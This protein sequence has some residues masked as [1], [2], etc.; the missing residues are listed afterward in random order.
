MAVQ[1]DIKDYVDQKLIEQSNLKRCPLFADWV[2]QTMELLRDI[3][4]R[5]ER[6]GVAR[7]EQIGAPRAKARLH[8][9]KILNPKFSLKK[10]AEI[11]GFAYGTV[12][13]WTSDD[14]FLEQ[15]NNY[16]GLFTLFYLTRLKELMEKR[17]TN[18][19][20]QLIN[21]LEQ[22]QNPDVV[23]S[24]YRNYL[25]FLESEDFAIELIHIHFLI[26]LTIY[27]RKDVGDEETRRE[28]L[29]QFHDYE[30][31]MMETAFEFLAKSIAKGDKKRAQ[32]VADN[33]KSTVLDYMENCKELSLKFFDKSGKRK[34]R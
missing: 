21:E 2:V 5:P 9:Y 23:L 1:K 13:N 30:K 29:S 31:T 11:Y 25:S 17:A 10:Y 19:V 7:G 24:I 14:E 27:S 3:P 15:Y 4:E 28:I 8:L 33:L 18:E 20:G 32:N 12:R 34:N 22:Y 6:K 16:V 26:T